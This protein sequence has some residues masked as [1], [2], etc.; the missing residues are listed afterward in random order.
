MRAASRNRSGSRSPFAAALRIPSAKTV[1]LVVACCLGGRQVHAWSRTSLNSAT[2]FRSK[3]TGLLRRTFASLIIQQC[4]SVERDD[5]ATTAIA[6]KGNS[7]AGLQ[8]IVCKLVEDSEG[9]IRLWQV[10]K[11]LGPYSRR[12]F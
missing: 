9:R 7:L 4:V 8:S 1:R 6:P 2:V 5:N 11:V 3:L 12:L 10:P